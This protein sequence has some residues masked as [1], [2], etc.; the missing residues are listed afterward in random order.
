[1]AVFS[2]VCNTWALEPAK[3][4]TP[5]AKQ[6]GAGEQVPAGIANSIKTDIGH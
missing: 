2:L 4:D 1:M 5:S 3:P 6:T